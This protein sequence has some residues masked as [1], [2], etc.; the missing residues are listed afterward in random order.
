MYDFEIPLIN[1]YSQF[2]EILSP[3]FTYKFYV[4]VKYPQKVNIHFNYHLGFIPV[5]S[6]NI[7]EYSNKSFVSELKK[8]SHILDSHGN[9]GLCYFYL[10]EPYTI[11]NPSTTYIVFEIIPKFNW[12][13]VYVY[14]TLAVNYEFE[15]IKGKSKNLEFLSANEIYRFYIAAKCNKTINFEIICED[16]NNSSLQYINIYEFSNRKS[17]I[18]LRYSELDLS[19]NST[20]KTYSQSYKVYDSSTIYV[21]FELK[22]NYN[23]HQVYVKAIIDGDDHSDNNDKEGKTTILSIIIILIIIVVCIMIFLIY[24]YIKKYKYKKMWK[25]FTSESNET[26]ETKES[27][28]PK[29]L[30]P[31]NQE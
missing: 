4:S 22:P 27:K 16:S 29:S 15:L 17:L 9:N 6:I 8:T 31:I 13:S 3:R 11:S 24:R 5:E 18:E 2:V 7:Y 30:Y 25:N 23:M 1:G 10:V 14:T 12:N 26:K 19:Y 21:A 20:N 28:E